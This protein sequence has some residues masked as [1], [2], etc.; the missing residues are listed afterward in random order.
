MILYKNGNYAT[1][2]C[3]LTIPWG[4]KWHSFISHLSHSTR[5]STNRNGN[6]FSWNFHGWI[7]RELHSENS[8]RTLVSNHPNNEPIFK[9]SLYPDFL[10]VSHLHSNSLWYKIND[11]KYY[12]FWCMNYGFH[13]S[14]FMK[15]K[16]FSKLYFV[17]NK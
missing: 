2:D 6:I 9:I 11:H 16:L 14:G 10:E 8:D 3:L 15:A 1:L 13:F 7:H 17:G 12:A 5:N 4:I